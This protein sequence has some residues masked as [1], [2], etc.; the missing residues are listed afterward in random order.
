MAGAPSGVTWGRGVSGMR[1]EL[2]ARRVWQE[3][4]EE[5]KRVVTWEAMH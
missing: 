5:V 1:S 2:G 3:N 4:Q